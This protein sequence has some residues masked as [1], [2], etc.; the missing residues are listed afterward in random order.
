[1]VT[2]NAAY[3]NKS[4][5]VNTLNDAQDVAA[6]LRTLKFEVKLKENVSAWQM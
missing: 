5:P 2:I 4:L 6:K 3:K 1:L